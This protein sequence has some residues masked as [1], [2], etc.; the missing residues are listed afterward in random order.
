MPRQDAHTGLPTPSPDVVAR[1][2]E[3]EVVLVHLR[4][5]KIF[6]LNQ[7]GTRFWQLLVDGASRAEI[8]SILRREYDVAHDEIA[9]EIDLLVA[10]LAREGI[11]TATATS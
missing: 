1:E 6:A 10:E 8:E 7:T 11:V 9:D 2:L 4:T 5:N 3:D